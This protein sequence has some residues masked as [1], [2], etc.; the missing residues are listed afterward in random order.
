MKKKED[1]RMLTIHK[2]NYIYSFYKEH[3]IAEKVPSGTTMKF[4]T[5]DCYKDQIQSEAT[6]YH[7]VDWNQINPATG[8]IFVEGAE[9]G[10]VLKVTIHEI[11]ISDSGIMTTGKGMGAMGHRLDNHAIKKV[12]IRDDKVIFNDKVELPV[13]PMIGVIG[14]APEKDAISCETPGEHGGNMDTKLISTGSTLYLPVFQPGA[15][16]ALGDLH[17]AMGDGEVGISGVEVSGEVLVTLDVLKGKTIP[18]PLIENKEG[19]AVIVSKPT[20][21]EAAKVAVEIFADLLQPLTDLSLYELTMLF[22]AAGQVQV[23]QIVDPL[24]TVRFFI[25]KAI[26]NA[27]EINLFRE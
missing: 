26:L 11:N 17:A 19:L 7:S 18:Y 24:M 9:P 1:K 3:P 27:Y 10:D 23:S 5:Y 12:D 25:P 2:V 8:P 15:L 4:E 16:F 22:S 20:L 6:P 21:D 14:V 13:Q